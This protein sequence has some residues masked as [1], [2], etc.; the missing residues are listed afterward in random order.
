MDR[1]I[2]AMPKHGPA[3]PVLFTLLPFDLKVT[4]S[5]A[6]GSKHS[7]CSAPL[8]RRTRCMR[9][10]LIITMVQLLQQIALSCVLGH[11]DLPAC[12]PSNAECSQTESPVFANHA[13]SLILDC[14]AHSKGDAERL[15]R[16]LIVL[17][18]LVEE[19]FRQ[20]NQYQSVSS[21]LRVS[22]LVAARL[23]SGES[24]NPLANSHLIAVVPSRLGTSS[25]LLHKPKPRRAH[26]YLPLLTKPPPLLL[27][28]DLRLQARAQGCKQQ[29]LP[30]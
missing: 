18:L 1:A 14:A 27:H 22:D 9:F 17:R 29:L 6:L 10:H 15:L 25:C 21:A 12:N 16:K 4:Q 20:D 11:F 28:L 30:I 24:I 19:T 7:S 8:S 2:P 13:E 23:A 3:S 5:Q 26:P